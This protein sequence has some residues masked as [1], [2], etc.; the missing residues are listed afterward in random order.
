MFNII[1]SSASPVCRYCKG[2]VGVDGD[3]LDYVSDYRGVI[4]FRCKSWHNYMYNNIVY[5]INLL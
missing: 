4:C 3:M 5:E 1:F 2:Y